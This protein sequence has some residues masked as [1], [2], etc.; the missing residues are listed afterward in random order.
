MILMREHRAATFVRMK[1]TGI[2]LAAIFFFGVTLSA[3]AVAD[4]S[5]RT[6]AADGGSAA[7]N[8]TISAGEPRT[9]M[10]QVKFSD[11]GKVRRVKVVEGPLSLRRAAINAVKRQT[12]IVKRSSPE[13]RRILLAV[14]FDD[15]SV[16]EIGQLWTPREE[17]AFANIPATVLSGA[18]GCVHT[19]PML[20]VPKW[21]MES[22]LVKQVDPVYP[23]SAKAKHIAGTVT[24]YV[25]I[26]ELGNVNDAAKVSG[27][28]F[29]V[30]AAV[31]AVMQRK[32]QPYTLNGIP[33]KV[34]TLV[35]VQ[36]SLE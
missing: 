32:Y 14:R 24:L 29:L 5:E 25:H 20:R 1:R 33:V 7:Q 3:Q 19:P 16:A 23:R 36:F 17:T 35:D 9:V 31:D 27:S 8:H 26:D 18:L 15:A 6:V 10:L 12:Y 4:C 13:L 28:N 34:V 11:S 2:V 30:A 22:R 21:V